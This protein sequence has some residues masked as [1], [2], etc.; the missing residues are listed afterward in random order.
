MKTTGPSGPVVFNLTQGKNPG[1]RKK[2]GFFDGPDAHI[3]QQFTERTREAAALAEEKVCDFPQAFLCKVLSNGKGAA[4]L[5]PS[6]EIV[7][8]RGGEVGKIQHAEAA[9]LVL[10]PAYRGGEYRLARF[11]IHQRKHIR[12]HGA[13][14][15]LAALGPVAHGGGVAA[16]SGGAPSRARAPGALPAP[17]RC[18][19]RRIPDCLRRR[20]RGRCRRRKTAAW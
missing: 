6:L 9:S 8:A 13:H 18:P 4:H 5:I 12:F 7:I 17:E 10:L 3:G 14:G 16:G 11:G 2:A 20:G 15:G 19:G 1:N